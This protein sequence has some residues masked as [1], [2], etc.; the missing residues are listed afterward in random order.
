MTTSNSNTQSKN[1]KTNSNYKANRE[2]LR[3]LSATAKELV[4]AGEVA[5]VNEGLIR[6]YQEDGEHKEFKTFH[7][8]KDDGKSIK[9]GSKA[10]MVW[11][12]PKE[13]PHPDPEAED[14]QME[15]FPIC[16]LF[17]NCQVTERRSS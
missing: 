17:S 6:M 11:G 12:S 10:F 14:D 16:Y 4:E 2:A 5:T 7:Q 8:W 9:K 3:V 1:T 15:Y 13:I